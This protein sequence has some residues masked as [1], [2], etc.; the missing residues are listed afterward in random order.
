MN[1]W[2]KEKGRETRLS[3]RVRDVTKVKSRDKAIFV[4]GS[5]IHILWHTKTAVS[6]M[7]KG[8]NRCQRVFICSIDNLL[9]PISS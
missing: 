4:R 5:A 6:Q 2:T 9:P 3:E 1:E 7:K 8:N